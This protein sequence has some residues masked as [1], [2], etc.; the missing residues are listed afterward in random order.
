MSIASQ[1]QSSTV[2]FGT[3]KE[4]AATMDAPNSVDT[5]LAHLVPLLWDA[6]WTVKMN[7]LVE[8][9]VVP[10]ARLD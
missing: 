7:V 6:R 9:L 1:G 8:V 4:P 2:T 10:G 5:L 3:T